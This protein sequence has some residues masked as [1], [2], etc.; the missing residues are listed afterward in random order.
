MKQNS[1]IGARLRLFQFVKLYGLN[2]EE[3]VWILNNR[4]KRRDERAKN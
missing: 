2:K 3:I 1:K 4:I